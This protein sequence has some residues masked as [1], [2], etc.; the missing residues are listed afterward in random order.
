MPGAANANTR[1]SPATNSRPPA[2]AVDVKWRAWP[3]PN[4]A[5]VAPVAGLSAYRIP[6]STF[7]THTAP[8]ATIG[9]PSATGPWNVPTAAIVG[10]ETPKSRCTARMPLAQGTYTI[11]VALSYAPPPNA[12]HPGIAR[13]ASAFASP[14]CVP[15]RCSE[16]TRN[17]TC[18]LPTTNASPFPGP[19]R[20]GPIEPRSAS[21]ELHTAQLVGPNAPSS[22]SVGES[23]T[24]ELPWS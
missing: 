21:C 12:A 22:V 14:T 16:S 1:V 4:V 5:T 6:A 20:T 9:E 18:C 17:A 2:V 15:L 11:D 3:I 23:F 24:T 13:C 7:V 8:P 19:T 10:G